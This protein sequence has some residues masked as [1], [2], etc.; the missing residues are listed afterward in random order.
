MKFKLCFFGSIFLKL[1]LVARLSATTFQQVPGSPFPAGSGPATSIFSPVVLGNLFAAVP[2]YSSN[3]ISVYEVNQTTGA[4]TEV[5]LSPFATGSLPAWA[6]FSPITSSGKLFAAVANFNDNTVTVY[7]VDET[8]GEFTQVAG[9]PFSTGKGPVSVEFSPLASGNLF[10]VV[11][12]SADNDV[13]VYAVNQNTGTFTQVPG[14]PFPTGALPNNATF[15]P[16]VAGNLF[17][18]V[19][20]FNDDTVSVYEVNQTTGAFTSVIGS[21]FATGSGPY[22]VN[23]SPLASGNLFAA[24]TNDI[25]NTI[26]VFEVNQTTGTFTEV[27]SSPFSAGSGTN[28]IAFSPIYMGNLYAAAVNFG[29]N[30]VSLYQVNQ[31]TGFFTQLPGSPFASG[32]N[33]DGIAFSPI[34][35]GNLFAA[36][37]NFGDSTVSVYQLISSTISPPSNLTAV[38]LTNQ[39]LT[40]TE[41]VNYLT[42][43]A[44]TGGVPA[45]GYK[46]FLNNLSNLLATIYTSDPI[47]HFEDCHVKKGVS[48]TYFIESIDASGNVSQ[49]ISI[50]IGG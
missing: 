11:A 3:T 4:F 6:A 29:S 36:V 37:A 20:N 43:T 15:S 24:V 17:A 26:S 48:Y 7:S 12:N 27:P 41:Y 42:W 13:S 33:P 50:T 46:I 40:W 49:P 30:D 14:S 22:N 10:A 25:G 1:L 16:L 19:V 8:T 47:V 21:P 5:P 35:S 23:F 44:P 31:T 2:N 34:V 45:V 9:S 18:A 38:Q 32:I 39:F 28:Q